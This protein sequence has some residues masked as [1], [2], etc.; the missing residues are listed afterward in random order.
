MTSAADQT[1]H[2]TIFK[3]QLTDVTSTLNRA[4]ADTQHSWNGLEISK[5][6][7]LQLWMVPSKLSRPENIGQQSP[8]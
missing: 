6:L 3:A 2:E 7:E 4:K 1:R 5:K 8:R